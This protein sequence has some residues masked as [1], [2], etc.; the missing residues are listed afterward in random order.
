[1]Q[2]MQHPDKKVIKVWRFKYYVLLALLIIAFAMA[3]IFASF[4][5][6]MNLT[7]FAAIMFVLIAAAVVAAAAI[8][9]KLNY[10]RRKYLFTEDKIEIVKGIIFIETSMIPISRI[11]HLTIDE[12]PLLRRHNLASIVVYTTA[13]FFK[14]EELARKDAYMIADYLKNTVNIKVREE[15]ENNKEAQ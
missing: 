2:K 13:G 9:P 6:N 15:D 10:K 4:S 8:F 11:Q 1:M 7:I 14:M 3:I 12:G 5:G